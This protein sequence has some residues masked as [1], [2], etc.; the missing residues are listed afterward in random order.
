MKMEQVRALAARMGIK[1]GKMKKGE[2]IRS[3]QQAEG[4]NACFDTGT[5]DR[6]G[7]QDCLWREDC[8]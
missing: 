1:T 7:Q 5:A 8:R 3:I 4:N 6:C 2:L